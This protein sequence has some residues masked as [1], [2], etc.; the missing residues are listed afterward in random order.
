[1][2]K[3]IY[4][5]DKEDDTSLTV[6]VDKQH[7]G[8]EMWFRGCTTSIYALTGDKMSYGIVDK[9]LMYR[10]CKQMINQLDKEGI[11]V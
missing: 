8:L 5:W 3:R 4:L 6:E 10:F 1:M 11:V 9:K 7:S 2:V